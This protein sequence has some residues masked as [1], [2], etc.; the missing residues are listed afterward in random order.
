[1]TT[2]MTLMTHMPSGERNRKYI[3]C[4]DVGGDNYIKCSDVG[5]DNYIIIVIRGFRA[6]S[7]IAYYWSS[8]LSTYSLLL[9]VL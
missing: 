5:G 8:Y 2:Q 1:M 3:K 9:Q 4:S 7:V 6:C